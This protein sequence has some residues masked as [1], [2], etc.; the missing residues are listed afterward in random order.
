VS[1]PSL[2][3][4]VIEFASE[5]HKKQFENDEFKSAMMVGG[6]SGKLVVMMASSVWVINREQQAKRIEP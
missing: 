2:R 6:E 1:D 5:E 3:Q 4:I